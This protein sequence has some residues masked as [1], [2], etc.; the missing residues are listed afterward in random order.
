MQA[1]KEETTILQ[2]IATFL[3]E[4]SYSETFFESSWKGPKVHN[5][6]WSKKF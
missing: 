5:M 1:F 4:T 6:I 3:K 2:E